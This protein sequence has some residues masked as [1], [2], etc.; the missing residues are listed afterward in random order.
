VNS[1]SYVWDITHQT[2][3]AHSKQTKLS[4]LV[5]YSLCVS[6]SSSSSSLF[7]RLLGLYL[8]SVCVCVCVCVCVLCVLCVARVHVLAQNKSWL[9][10]IFT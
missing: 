3:T 9:L 5:V 7:V 1:T 6:L 2:N 4:P 8:C 10:A